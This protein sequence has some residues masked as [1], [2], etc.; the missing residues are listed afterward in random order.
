[1]FS[2]ATAIELARRLEPFE[3]AWIEEPVPPDNLEMLARAA[4]KVSLPIATGERLHTRF[5]ALRLLELGCVD[6]LQTD[7][8]QS[9]GLLDGQKT[10]AMAA[11]RYVSFAPHNVGGP[12]STAACLHLAACTTNFRI[13]EHFNDFVDPWVREAATGPGY[14]AVVDGYF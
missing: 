2:P 7:I 12:V 13:Q 1:R 8:T 6:I 14:P 5:E 9:C 3:P 4:A 11:S 10:A